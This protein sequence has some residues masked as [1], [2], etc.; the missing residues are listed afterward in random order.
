METVQDTIRDLNLEMF[1]ESLSE[2]FECG[3]LVISVE[4]RAGHGTGGEEAENEE[5]HG[6]GG[7]GSLG[8]SDKTLRTDSLYTF[9]TDVT[10]FTGVHCDKSFMFFN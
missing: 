5:L 8:L 6:A 9:F 7:G 1:L 4:G 2:L 10:A 3:A